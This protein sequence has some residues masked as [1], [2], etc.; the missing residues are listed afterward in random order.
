MKK[1]EAIIGVVPNYDE[2]SDAS[3]IKVDYLRAVYL[4]GG[5]PL[6]TASIAEEGYYDN[7][8]EICSGFIISGSSSDV[9]PLRYG[10][11]PIAKCGKI[12]LKREE[13][14]WLLLKYI[15]KK[16]V[17]LLGICHG[18]QEINVYC[19][20][21]LYQDIQSQVLGAVQHRQLNKPDQPSHKVKIEKKSILYEIIGQ[22]EILV[23]SRH[24]Q[25]ID[26]LGKDLLS[27]ATS[28][29]NLIEAIALNSSNHFVL[30][31]QW[32]PES[33]IQHN[34]HSIKIFK[35]FIRK[36]KQ[37]KKDKLQIL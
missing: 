3:K 17:P 35:Y 5:I 12:N 16:K 30:A 11:E 8:T 19:G 1:N 14:D 37:Y 21:S 10:Q 36:C 4:G 31:V 23:N 27:V 15:F 7:L 29:D 2:E 20:G 26:K 9:N 22:E 24:H 25:A 13:C 33:M 6:I 34:E 28:E 18:L 32:H